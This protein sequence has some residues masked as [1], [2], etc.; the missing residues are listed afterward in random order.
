MRSVYIALAVAAISSSATWWIQ[1]QH[2]G[3]IIAENENK[4][5]NLHIQAVNEKLEL[6]RAY[7]KNEQIIIELAEVRKEKQKVLTK[8][9]NNDVIKYVQ[10]PIAGKCDIPNEWV[11]IHD[12]AT[13]GSEYLQGDT[14]P[15]AIANAVAPTVTDADA[16]IVIADN[17]GTCNEI[18]NN[19]IDLQ[20]WVNVYF[21]Q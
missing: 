13:I 8:V 10:S 14:S 12:A 6:D 1:S 7:R 18:R 20:S 9:I 5:L 19:L 3:K 17:Y 11:R 2:Y 4:A 16:I 15:A 21:R